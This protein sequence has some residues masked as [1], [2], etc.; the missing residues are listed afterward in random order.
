LT[1]FH[2]E[3]VGLLIEHDPFSMLEATNRGEISSQTFHPQEIR[4]VVLEQ[5][6]KVMD[7]FRETTKQIETV[8]KLPIEVTNCTPACAV[9]RDR[10]VVFSRP[11]I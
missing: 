8:G 5:Q 4:Q 9:G 11:L 2:I 10:R 7:T 1:R 3:K 6:H